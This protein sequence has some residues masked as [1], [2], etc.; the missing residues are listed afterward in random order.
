MLD[1][2]ARCLSE[3]EQSAGIHITTGQD[4]GHGLMH[5]GRT[6]SLDYLNARF[7][8]SVVADTSIPTGEGNL[9]LLQGMLRA[10]SIPVERATIGLVGC[11]NIGM[12]IVSRLREEHPGVTL[13]VCES[14]ADRRA[15]LEAMGIRTTAAEAKA[16]F[17]QMPMDAL[18]VNAAGGTLDRASVLACVANERLRVVCGSENL[19]MPEPGLEELLRQAEKVFAPTELGGMMGYLTAVEQY[20]SVIEK[21]P[22]LV[23]AMLGAAQ[24][25]ETAGYE[26][27]ARIIANGHVEN[28]EEAV[29]AVYAAGGSM[30]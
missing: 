1:F 16:A 25:L 6:Q 9:R 22:F 13:L 15:E 12:H 20:L 10:W 24:R 26:T 29:T 28:F 19:V 7:A 8:G 18:V 21:V 11:G 2:A 30:M 27:T 5:D 4:L 17:L 3:V 14:R 23:D